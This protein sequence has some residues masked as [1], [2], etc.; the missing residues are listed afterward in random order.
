MVEYRQLPSDRKIEGAMKKIV[1]SLHIEARYARLNSVEPLGYED[2]VDR[3]QTMLHA[4]ESSSYG[5]ATDL[6]L[7]NEYEA[8]IG[9]LVAMSNELY[10]AW[11]KEY[12]FKMLAKVLIAEGFRDWTKTFVIFNEE[13][14]Q[15]WVSLIEKS[16]MRWDNRNS[17]EGYRYLF[18]PVCN[19]VPELISMGTGKSK[20]DNIDH[21]AHSSHERPDEAHA[22]PLLVECFYGAAINVADKAMAQILQIVN[23][24]QE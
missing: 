24:V 19:W 18:P 17:F 16:R 13:Y 11:A 6:L 20:L 1:R 7:Q 23:S 12:A 10:V 3:V 15:S 8:L 5:A 9:Q 22:H 21:P 2:L 14:R 4:S